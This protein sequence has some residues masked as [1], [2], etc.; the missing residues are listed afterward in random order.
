MLTGQSR[1][2]SEPNIH[3]K[4][5]LIDGKVLYLGSMNLSTNAIENNREIGIVIADPQ[6]IRRFTT[7]FDRDRTVATPFY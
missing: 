1:I 4:N 3:A 7:Q 6:V 2:L 5:I